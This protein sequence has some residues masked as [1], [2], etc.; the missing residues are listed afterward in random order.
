[1]IKKL[2]YD[3]GNERD[4]CV[5]R[6]YQQRLLRAAIF[7]LLGVFLQVEPEAISWTLT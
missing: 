7:R 2:E 6:K 3:A 1:M 5:L 4:L